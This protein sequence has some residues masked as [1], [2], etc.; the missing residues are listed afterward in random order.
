[1]RIFLLPILLIII[2]ASQ[3]SCGLGN[4][5][6]QF[7]FK[8]LIIENGTVGNIHAGDYVPITA[9]TVDAYGEKTPASD[10]VQWVIS[11]QEIMAIDDTGNLKALSP[12]KVTIS[13]SFSVLEDSIE[14]EVLPPIVS[15]NLL[16]DKP[17]KLNIDDKIVLTVVATLE[18][19]S[20]LDVTDKTT[21]EVADEEIISKTTSNTFTVIK[22]GKT[23]IVATYNNST[24][25]LEF[26]IEKIVSVIKL[27]DKPIT[28]MAIGETYSPK[29][30]A[31]YTNAEPE[32]ITDL[33]A[34]NSTM[35]AF[36]LKDGTFTALHKGFVEIIAQYKDTV[37]TLPITIVDPLELFVKSDVDNKIVLQWHETSTPP[38]KLFWNTTGRV[39]S[40]N[41]NP[42]IEVGNS[43]SYT[44]ENAQRNTTYY[45]VLGHTKGGL[46]IPGNEIS[47][48][49]RLNRWYRHTSVENP[50]EYQSV[51]TRNEE[52]LTIGGYRNGEIQ[53][54]IEAI[55]L[56]THIITKKSEIPTARFNMAACFDGSLIHTFGG[57]IA[58][59]S[60]SDVYQIY[61]P[62]TDSWVTQHQTIPDTILAPLP[63]VLEGHTCHVK[64][65]IIYVF[66][67]KTLNSIN[68]KVYAYDTNN[69]ETNEW[70]EK[71][72][73]TEPRYDFTSHLVSEKIYIIGGQ[74][75]TGFP[76]TILIYDIAN[77]QWSTGNSLTHGLI[78][79]A[80]TL[81]GNQI[82]ITGVA[83]DGS[84]N[85]NSLSIY[86]TADNSVKPDILEF[87]SQRQNH[88]SFYYQDKLYSYGGY[89]NL[90]GVK[91]VETVDIIY[92]K[93]VEKYIADSPLPMP[94][95]PSEFRDNYYTTA[96]YKNGKRVYFFTGNI[97]PIAQ[98]D[99]LNNSWR[100]LDPTQVS[101][102]INHMNA[103]GHTT[104]NDVKFYLFGG[105]KP[106]NTISNQV[107]EYSTSRGTYSLKS[108][109]PSNNSFSAITSLD[110]TIYKIG[111]DKD[112]QK[113][114]AY[115]SSIDSWRSYA[116]MPTG[117]KNGTA[118]VHKG[119]VYVIGGQASDGTPLKT[120]ERFNMMLNTWE[121]VAP[122]HNSRY[123]A[124]SAII[125]EKIYVFGGHGD[126]SLNSVEVYDPFSNRWSQTSS[127]PQARHATTTHL[128]DGNLYLIG[129][130]ST[131]ADARSY[132]IDIFQ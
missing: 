104:S 129:G 114:F 108:L 49:P 98:L 5:S 36:A 43:T 106:D 76:S 73:M 78:G 34:W 33:V 25:T 30:E 74:N 122:I 113:V 21:F 88:I 103:V 44:F 69:D 95:I 29:L 70:I 100:D 99:T 4:D 10:K 131:D 120:V 107:R 97:K 48:R 132:V 7:E 42:P 6:F 56:D 67:G 124:S 115:R 116:D 119:Y 84:S 14:L 59:D 20:T 127:M 105:F 83:D 80:S 35:S 60:Y 63:V 68:N 31:T 38:E 90:T 117:R 52:L 91:P 50:Y 53:T 15:V 71:A 93:T 37:F 86:D 51:V 110:E 23:E 77:D 12:G 8:E 96:T 89:Y 47:V 27:T 62:E 39:N 102:T 13:A 18:D 1:M 101:Q 9:S 45:F 128:I 111:G 26:K 64:N 22:T 17:D 3:T 121:T 75:D 61:D 66:G 130:A 54:N 112:G 85:P 55:N 79:H 46:M 123:N 58:V 72:P 82:F 109:V 65:G 19:E 94:E 118:V 81:V 24:V 11:D 40:T 125:N 41:S 92:D 2:V 16:S 87:S 28:T 126:L 32:D 57:S